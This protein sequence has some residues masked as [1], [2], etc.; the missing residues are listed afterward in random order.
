M[1]LRIATDTQTRTFFQGKHVAFVGRLGGVTRREAGQLV[2]E[3]GGQM[4]DDGLAAD[5]I[6]IGADEPPLV[7]ERRFVEQRNSTSRRRWSGRD[8]V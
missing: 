5:L 7:S 4:E 3:H 8:F 6:V 2:R 1:E